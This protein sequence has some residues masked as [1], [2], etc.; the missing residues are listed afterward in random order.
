MD[1]KPPFQRRSVWKQDAK[2]YFIDTVVRGLPAPIIYLR[3]RID[4]KTQ[5]TIREVVD[6]QQ[7]L[8]TLFAYVDPGSLDDYDAARDVIQVR[9]IHNKDL[10]GKTFSRLS[11]HFKHRIL[12]YEFST[13]VL[14][15]NVEDREVLEMFA[16]LN[17]TGVKLSHQELRNAEWFG[18]MKTLLYAL[19]LEQ[20]ERWRDWKIF[21][22][23]QI[24]RMKEVELVG[25]LVL[26]MKN[27]LTAKTQKRLDL[28]YKN[29]DKELPEADEIRRRFRETMDAID[30]LLAHEIAESA[31]RSEIHFFTLFVFIY[32]LMYGLGSKL[33]RKAP[34]KLPSGLRERVLAVAKRLSAERVP[35]D[36]LDA[37]AR[38]SSDLGRRRTRLDY[39][40]QQC[41][42]V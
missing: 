34:K 12:S 9:P 6:G 1:L 14:P 17:A 23:D 39:M 13:H 7:R 4:L 26:N 22:G 21:N 8:R 36:V 25:D 42:V 24:S 29:Y 41:N 35:A 5:K 32:D 20:L 30:S 40:K 15:L 38:A 19:A 27:G 16:R 10:A 31:F 37:I 18:E 3:Q 33:K 11:D 28:L 2:S